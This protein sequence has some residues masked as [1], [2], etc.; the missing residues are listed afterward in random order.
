MSNYL[1]LMSFILFVL[2]ESGAAL[3]TWEWRAVPG[4]QI[5]HLRREWVSRKHL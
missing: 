1:A 2:P 5:V 3:G 4:V